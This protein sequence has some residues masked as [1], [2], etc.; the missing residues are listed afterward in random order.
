MNNEE[1]KDCDREIKFPIGGLWEDQDFTLK[2]N[3]HYS[4][5]CTSYVPCEHAT[6]IETSL[7]E[8]YYNRPPEVV[9]N[10][11]VPRV[12]IGMNEGGYNSVGICVDCIMKALK[13]FEG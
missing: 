12:V 2:L 6:E 9:R 8:Y 11:I 7:H 10:W 4:S 5:Y 1:D 13:Q 3:F